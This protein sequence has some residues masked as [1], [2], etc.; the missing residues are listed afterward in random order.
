VK[1]DCLVRGEGLN[2]ILSEFERF[3]KPSFDLY[4]QPT[5]KHADVVIPRGIAREFRFSSTFYFTFYHLCL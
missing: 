5:K 4:I 2:S 3:L 1:R